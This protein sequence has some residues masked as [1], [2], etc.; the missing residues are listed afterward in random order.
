MDR[1]DPWFGPICPR[2]ASVFEAIEDIAGSFVHAIYED[3]SGTMWVGMQD[4]TYVR[5]PVEKFQPK[6]HP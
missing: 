4:Q 1:Y 2:K 6:E 5:T 3:E